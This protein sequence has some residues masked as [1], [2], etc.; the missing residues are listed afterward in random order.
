[1]KINEIRPNE[2]ATRRKIRVGRGPGSGKGKTAGRGHKGQKSRSGYSR[3]FGFEGG[4]MPLVRRLPKRG[5]SNYPFKKEYVGIN[6]TML[7]LFENQDVITVDDFINKGIVKD[8]KDGIKILGNGEIN[9]PVTVR[10]HKFSKSAREK[11]EKAGGKCEV[12]EP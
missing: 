6:L 8:I 1:M 5:F 11:I 2:G 10:A 7:A 12:L 9:R 3:R 4:Q